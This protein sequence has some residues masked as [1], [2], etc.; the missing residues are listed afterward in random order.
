M[1]AQS[2]Q[3]ADAEAHATSGIACCAEP[4][5]DKG[6]QFMAVESLKSSAQQHAAGEALLNMAS[7]LRTQDVYH[8]ARSGQGLQ[9]L[10]APEQSSGWKGVLERVVPSIV[11]LK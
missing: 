9:T 7:K 10:A 6:K 11:V 5:T 4:E 8:N 3:V 2:P 1:D